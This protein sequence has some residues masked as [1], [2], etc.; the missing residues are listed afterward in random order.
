[1]TMTIRCGMRWANRAWSGNASCGQSSRNANAGTPSRSRPKARAGRCAPSTRHRPSTAEGW[2]SGRRDTSPREPS[3]EAEGRRRSEGRWCGCDRRSVPGKDRPHLSASGGPSGF[4][5]L[6]ISA[7]LP[8]AY[9][10]SVP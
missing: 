7:L 9:T 4:A 5:T 2:G 6:L 10:V 3:A 8:D 1:M